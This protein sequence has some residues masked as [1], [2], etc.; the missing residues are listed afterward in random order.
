[1]TILFLALSD[2]SF[3]SYHVPL[4]KILKSLSI[5]TVSEWRTPK[6][7]LTSDIPDT[8]FLLPFFW[9]V[10]S[11]V[12]ETLDEIVDSGSYWVV[13]KMIYNE[14]TLWIDVLLHRP[15]SQPIFF[16]CDG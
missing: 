12:L 1:M 8:T 2:P 10:K 16:Y 13:Y 3:K 9:E 5:I 15:A 4:K 6:V 14:N 11:K 7:Q